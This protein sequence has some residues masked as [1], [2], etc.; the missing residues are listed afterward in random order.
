MDRPALL[1]L[2]WRAAIAVT[3]ED[4]VPFLQGLVSNDVA[5]VSAG[6]AI[7]SAFLT[8]QGKFLHE[9]MIMRIGDRLLLDCERDRRADLLRRLK[10]YRLRSKVV[11]EESDETIV[12]LAGPGLD[13]ALG[14]MLAPGEAHSISGGVVYGDPRTAA[15]GWRGAVS[16]DGLASLHAQGLADASVAD[17]DRMRIAAGVPDGSRDLAVEKA[18]LLENGFDALNGI[19]WD[20][21]CYM[22]QEL[23][24]RTRYRGL[25]RKRLLPV[26]IE[27][28]PPAPDAD[29]TRGGKLVGQVRSVSEDRALVLLRLEALDDSTEPLLAG[30]AHLRPEL[31][32]WFSLP[33]PDSS[34]R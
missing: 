2:E 9:F 26:R 18:I 28:A 6:H 10:I 31:P 3:G 4:A 7:W 19:D 15:M 12:G 27:G 5:R 34:S 14:F 22:G 29:V 30:E 8:P 11:I 21:G 20:K 33:D 17:W 23:T 32:D 24:A 16:A 13:Q 25:V 1:T